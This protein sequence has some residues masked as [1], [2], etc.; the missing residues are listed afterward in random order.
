MV[1]EGVALLLSSIRLVPIIVNIMN[2]I[3]RKMFF[4]ALCVLRFLW[5]LL[6]CF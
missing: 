6:R 3:F 4:I 5:F 2:D 1:L